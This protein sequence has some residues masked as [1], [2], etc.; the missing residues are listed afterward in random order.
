MRRR[1]LLLALAAAVLLPAQTRLTV[2]QLVEMVESSLRLKHQDKK[3]ADFLSKVQLTERLTES[4]VEDLQGQGAG[5]RTLEAL[6]QLKEQ[7][8]GLGAAQPVKAAPKPQIP[9][10]S[11]AEQERVLEQARQYARGYVHNLPDFICLQ[12]TRRYYDPTGLEFWR[13]NDE[14][15]TRLAYVEGREEYKVLTVN[16][17]YADIP[18]ERLGGATSSGEFGSMLKMIFDPESQAEFHWERWGTMRGRR[19]HVYRYRI[20]QPRSQWTVHHYA[21]GTIRPAVRGLVYVDGDTSMILTLTLEAENMPPGFPLQ[22]A[23]THLHF[24]FTRIG[25]EDEFLLPLRA[26]IRMR[27]GKF[28]VDNRIDFRRYRKFSAEAV[29]TFDTDLPDLLP[30]EVPETSEVDP[31]SKSGSPVEA[32]VATPIDPKQ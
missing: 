10:P 1:L 31:P 7:S 19:A 2:R 3:I 22:E 14:I 29:I 21:G 27:E 8:R 20:S 26:R 11:R 12:V 32:D 6:H 5:P 17:Q 24:D 18:V 9:P 15:A 30:D 23:S 25:D 16:N 13:K 4:A 28:L